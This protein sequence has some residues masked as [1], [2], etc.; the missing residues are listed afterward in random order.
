MGGIWR[1]QDRDPAECAFPAEIWVLT[2]DG[3][4]EVV[5]C[6]VV[7]RAAQIDVT[8]L[9]PGPSSLFLITGVTMTR[10]WVSNSGIG[11]GRSP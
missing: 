10:G 2:V 4:P 3:Q 9:K 5:R 6:N 11:T 8:K 1:L 7:L